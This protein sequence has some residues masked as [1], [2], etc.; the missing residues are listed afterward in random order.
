MKKMRNILGGLIITLSI[1]SC[2]DILDVAPEGSTDLEEIFLEEITAGAYLNTCY[3]NMPFYGG[4]DNYFNTNS[5]IGLSDDAWEY[6]QAATHTVQAVYDGK[7]S[8]TNN[9]LNSD[10]KAGNT[11]NNMF[12]GIRACNLFLQYI[13]RTPMS[14]AVKERWIAEAKVLRAYYN[15]ELIS[16][17]GG[18]PVIKEY[19]DINYDVSQYR[20][21]NF[22]TCADAI[23]ADC[24]DGISSANLPWRIT[25]GTEAGRMTKAV[26][27]AIKSRVILYAASPLWNEGQNY[28]D[29]AKIITKAAL[30]AC[31]ENGYA[32]YTRWDDQN[33]FS[34]SYQEYF[35][36][37]MP[38]YSEDPVDKETILA[39]KQEQINWLNVHGMFALQGANK[40]G[41]CPTQE[42]VDAYCMRTTGL[43]VLDLKNPYQDVYHVQPNYYPE[44]GYDS[45]KPYVNRDSRFYATIYYNGSERINDKSKLT[46]IGTYI[47]SAAPNK[48]GNCRTSLAFIQAEVKYTHT[49]YYV[50]KY[51]HPKATKKN[52]IGTKYPFYRL[53]EL[54]L[55]YAEAANEAG[56]TEEAMKQ[57][58][59]IRNRVGMPM[60]SVDVKSM[61]KEEAR[62]WIRNERR[63]ELAYEENRHYDLRRW[64]NPDGNLAQDM[65][66]LSGML[67]IRTT[68]G[69]TY[70][71]EL[72]R[73][74]IGDSYNRDTKK[75][76]GNKYPRRCVDN[77]WL[78]WPM[79]AAE[80]N[81]LETATGNRWQNPGW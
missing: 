73:F 63:V 59:I 70:T 53:A 56:D 37:S 60:P 29:E 24:N 47:D 76:L 36:K 67:P 81:R 18:L 9:L 11:W 28:W 72:V 16:R 61:T 45:K 22:K 58:E 23:I 62:L 75:W 74:T 42:L 69:K 3:A 35:C 6:H 52:K 34:S 14:D 7:V 66:Y 26:A 15:M 44:S 39:S 41:L 10:S 71:E 33:T 21:E 2:T 27:E 64:K 5:R 20:R 78:L 48:D 40:A 13:G 32:L 51:D 49:G 17:F 79:D 25:I 57:V 46:T 54:Y 43:P 19:H 68:A 31:L 12:A 80:V 30:D 38:D 50:R 4:Y 1:A 8:A 55:N 77:K 65:E